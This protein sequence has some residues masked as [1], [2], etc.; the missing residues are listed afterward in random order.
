MITCQHVHIHHDLKGEFNQITEKE[1]KTLVG[2]M[3][4]RAF[5]LLQSGY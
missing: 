1:T 5:V 4:I 2:L 3:I